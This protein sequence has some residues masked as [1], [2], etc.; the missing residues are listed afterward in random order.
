MVNQSGSVDCA[1]QRNG[2]IPDTFAVPELLSN[3]V[4]K[5]YKNGSSESV[6]AM[7]SV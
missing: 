7:P 2:L 3:S 1:D 6:N 4:A 5:G